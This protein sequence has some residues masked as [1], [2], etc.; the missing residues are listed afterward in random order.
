M[1]KPAESC[2]VFLTRLISLGINRS[3]FV[4]QAAW[5]PELSTPKKHTCIIDF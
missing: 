3:S 5:G 1:A 2:I 4:E